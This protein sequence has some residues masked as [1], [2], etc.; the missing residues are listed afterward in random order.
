VGT[1]RLFPLSFGLECPLTT[2]SLY[3]RMSF[4]GRIDVCC[5]PAGAGLAGGL[6]SA[7]TAPI[8]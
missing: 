4:S 3:I 1:G 6:R 8:A 2:R 7:A 5:E